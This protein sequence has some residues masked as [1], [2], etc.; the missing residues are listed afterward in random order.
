MTSAVGAGRSARRAT[1]N[2]A[3]KLLGRVG[4]LGLGILNLLL[5]FLAVQIALGDRGEKADRGG[6]LATL[7][8]QPFGKGLLWVIA[9]G[10]AALALWQLSEAIWGFAYAGKRR[11]RR[12]VTAGF[13]AVLFGF[14]AYSA[15]KVAAGSPSGESSQTT[16]AKLMAEPFGRILVGVGG[17]AI[18]AVAAFVVYHGISKRFVE[19]LDLAQA[20][21]SARN[22]AVRLGQAG[23]ASVGIAYVIVGIFV[24]V[25]AVRYQPSKSAGLDGALKTLAGQPYGTV[26]LFVIALGFA[27]YGV[28]CFFD[29]RYHRG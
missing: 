2:D 18:I 10:L 25:A 15:A 16:T 23:Y 27:C 3:V 12:R 13:K 28:Y 22:A 17:L 26:V 8:D 9:A 5:A 7:A 14:F 21:P 1:N 29:A 24:V 20:S 19:D 6:A 4:L 11:T